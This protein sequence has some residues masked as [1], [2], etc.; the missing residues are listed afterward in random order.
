MVN[1]EKFAILW[2]L[3]Y[4]PGS[5]NIVFDTN[6]YMKISMKFF[7]DLMSHDLKKRIRG[8]CSLVNSVIVTAA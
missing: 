5:E 4:S 2:H 1:T 8:H 3:V 7:A 6:T